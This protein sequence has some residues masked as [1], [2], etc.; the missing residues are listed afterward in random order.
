MP[1]ARWRYSIPATARA[2]LAAFCLVYRGGGGGEY[3]ARRCHRSLLCL[4]RIAPVEEYDPETSWK[5]PTAR[6]FVACASDRPNMRS[7]NFVP[8][9]DDFSERSLQSR[10]WQ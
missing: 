1:P 4:A 10:P 8:T 7:E 5:Y 9:N 3:R 6:M 2:P